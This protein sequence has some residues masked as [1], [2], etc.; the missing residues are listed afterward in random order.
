MAK[1][2]LQEALAWSNRRSSERTGEMTIFNVP[3]KGPWEGDQ[4]VECPECGAKVDLKNPHIQADGECVCGF[5]IVKYF[6]KNF[7]P[8]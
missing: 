8:G 2:K 4:E 7:D 5:E 3:A 1:S 6:D